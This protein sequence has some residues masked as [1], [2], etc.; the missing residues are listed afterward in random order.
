MQNQIS[1]MSTRAESGIGRFDHFRF[2][3]PGRISIN[4]TKQLSG[5][6]IVCLLL[7]GPGNLQAVDAGGSPE[8]RQDIEQ[9]LRTGGHSATHRV[10]RND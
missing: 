9:L 6:L 1:Y 7:C 8:I 5:L 4:F 10:S 2:F 3:N